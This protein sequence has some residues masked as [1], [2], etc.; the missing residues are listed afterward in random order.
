MKADIIIEQQEIPNANLRTV[1]NPI[2]RL[3]NTL[4]G[5]DAEVR[6]GSVTIALDEIGQLD[7]L[8]EKLQDLRK[9]WVRGSGTSSFFATKI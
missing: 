7:E 3:D 2:K 9:M 8:L 1:L 6:I 5:Y 4:I